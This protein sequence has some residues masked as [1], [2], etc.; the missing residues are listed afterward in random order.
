[1]FPLLN[2]HIMTVMVFDSYLLNIY[3]LF[4]LSS[5]NSLSKIKSR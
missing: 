2:Q 3:T 1:M 5:A 4:Q